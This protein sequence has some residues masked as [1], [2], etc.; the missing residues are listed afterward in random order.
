M[1]YD[2]R[3]YP[4]VRKIDGEE[5]EGKNIELKNTVS[6]GKTVSVTEQKE[7]K[8]WNNLTDFF[9]LK[10]CL[11]NASKAFAKNLQS[12]AFESKTKSKI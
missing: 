12:N 9:L 10:L 4:G 11:N 6:C 2:K 7:K 3:I 8:N 5:R 1:N